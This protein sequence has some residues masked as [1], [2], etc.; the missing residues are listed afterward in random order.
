MNDSGDIV[1]RV[2]SNSSPAAPVATL[3]SYLASSCGH[4][5][6]DRRVISQGFSFH[7]WLSDEIPHF[8]N[9]RA[10]TGKTNIAITLQCGVTMTGEDPF[11]SCSTTDDARAVLESAEHE[12]SVWVARVTVGTRM[13]DVHEIASQAFFA[14]HP[15]EFRLIAEELVAVGVLGDRNCPMCAEHAERSSAA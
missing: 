15:D 6:L 12:T 2:D 11:E 14:E 13:Y 8:F 1:A 10:S 9:K 5:S 7:P 3:R 4:V